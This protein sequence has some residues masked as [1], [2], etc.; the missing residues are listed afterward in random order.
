MRL[1]V[2]H[3]LALAV[4][5]S[6]ANHA[7]AQNDDCTGALSIAQG[8][9]GPYSNVGATTSAPAWPCG[10]GQND[11]WFSYLAP[12]AGTLVASTCTG[13]NY[14]STLE[15]F[16]AAGGCG[17]LVS[18]GCNDDTCGTQSTVTVTVA[19]GALY[20]IRVGGWNGSV[21]TFSLD[22]NGPL[23]TGV[24]ATNTVVGAGCIRQANSFYEPMLTAAP[25]AAAL[26]GNVLLLSPTGT[27]YQ[28]A[29]LPGAAS[30]FFVTPVAPVPLATGDD[31]VVTYAI[32]TGTLQTPQGPQASLL[33][34]GNGI[35]TWGGAAI[36]Y[37][38]T[39][40]YQP[41]VPGFLNST[42]G[43]LYAWHDYN[44]AEAGSGQIVAEEIGGVLYLTWNGVENY[45][46][47]VVNPSTMQLQLNLGSGVVNMVFLSIDG[48]TASPYGSDHLIGVS[49]PGVSQDPGAISLATASAAQLLTVDPEVLPLV[50]GAVSRPV[51]GTS[52][53]LNLTNVPANAVVGVDVFGIGDPGLNDLGFLGA[54]GC[55]LRSSLDLLNA[56]F[57]AGASHA[58]SLP[59]PNNPALLNQHVYTTSAVFQFPAQNAFGAIT[60]NGIEGK[61]GDL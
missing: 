60:S 30:A 55:G 22:I 10:T 46:A 18:L 47:G 11:V 31:G 21:G 44:Q 8:L 20:Y 17:A 43:G 5:T 59:V 19:Q 24:V 26:T 32:T 35:V 7:L 34:S 25:A 6:L 16:D 42:L 45:P 50:L 27:G 4:S 40:S 23:G 37:P 2:L 57:P 28:G 14:D 1:P 51:T 12:A 49:G 9:N 39:N 41:T 61:V 53:N 48:N 15:I 29:W 58:Y 3:L 52:W 33:V 38:G 56:W 36:D 13:T 54:P